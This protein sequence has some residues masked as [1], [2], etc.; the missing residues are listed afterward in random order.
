MLSGEFAIMLSRELSR[1]G[2]CNQ[3]RGTAHVVGKVHSSSRESS[4]RRESSIKLS[5]EFMPSAEFN[6]ALRRAHAI[7]NFEAQAMRDKHGVLRKVDFFGGHSNIL[8]S[9]ESRM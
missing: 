7:G 9:A 6:Q 5:G 8:K 1:S 4:C 2:E 3:A